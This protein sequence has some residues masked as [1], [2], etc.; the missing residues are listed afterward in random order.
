M[1]ATYAFLPVIKRFT[2][3]LGIAVEKSDISVAARVLAHFPGIQNRMLACARSVKAIAFYV[4]LKE[5][6]SADFHVHSQRSSSLTRRCQ[7]T[8]RR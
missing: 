7:I 1:L 2:E 4:P 3:P 8:S 6:S 5:Y